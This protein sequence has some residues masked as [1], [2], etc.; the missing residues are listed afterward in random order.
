[1][2]IPMQ[3]LVA[4]VGQEKALELITKYEGKPL[5]P[6]RAVG[7][8]ARDEEIRRL[9]NGGLSLAVVAE[10]L[11]VSYRTVLRVIKQRRN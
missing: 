9:W 5:P 2:Q 1:M 10:R 11:G 7:K 6:L 3:D 4:I 8:F